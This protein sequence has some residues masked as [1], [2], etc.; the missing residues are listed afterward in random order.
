M[1]SACR[2]S[3]TCGVRHGNLVADLLA[4][5][6]PQLLRIAF[7]VGRRS[8]VAAYT[9]NNDHPA[10]C[11]SLVATSAASDD[12]L[13]GSRAGHCSDR[14]VQIT[15]QEPIFI[16]GGFRSCGTLW[17]AGFVVLSVGHRSLETD[18]RSSHFDIQMIPA[19]NDNLP[20]T[21]LLRCG[22]CTFGP[23]IQDPDSRLEVS[24]LLRVVTVRGAARGSYTRC[25]QALMVPDDRVLGTIALLHESLN[26]LE[27]TSPGHL[28]V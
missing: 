19:F 26:S 20:S 13:G 12:F 10:R 4:A 24:G 2:R 22:Q 5:K 27:I 23:G 18:L 7:S 6:Y 15:R 9:C 25:G 28:G 1:F 11:F 8:D 14:A 16:I 17:W 21:A 3:Q